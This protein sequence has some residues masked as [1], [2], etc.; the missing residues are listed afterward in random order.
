MFS[1]ITTNCVTWELKKEKR[2]VIK[3]DFVSQK[4]FSLLCQSFEDQRNH[5]DVQY[6]VPSDL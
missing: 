2:V 3:M 6:F 5:R 1:L 4:R